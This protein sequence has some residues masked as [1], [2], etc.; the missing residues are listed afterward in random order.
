MTLFGGGRGQISLLEMTFPEMSSNPVVV[1]RPSF[2]PLLSI[3]GQKTLSYSQQGLEHGK[4][5]G[6]NCFKIVS[7]ME[8]SFCSFN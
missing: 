1:D 4:E 6:R 5:K 7:L 8:N 2:L 3:S